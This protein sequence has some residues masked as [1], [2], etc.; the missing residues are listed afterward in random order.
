MQEVSRQAE[1]VARWS[2]GGM[3]KPGFQ[4]Y[5]VIKQTW[6]QTPISLTFWRWSLED[7]QF[8]GRGHPWTL[9]AIWNYKR[10]CL[11]ITTTTI[12]TITIGQRDDS[13]VAPQL[14][15]CTA[16]TEDQ[17]SVPSLTAACNSSCRDS[18]TFALH[19]HRQYTCLCARRQDHTHRIKNKIVLERWLS[20]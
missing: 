2:L 16:L 17:S 8:N 12:I 14:R 1:N 18:D 15:A 5:P 13:V 11:K 9:E 10:P 3:P 6:G 20:G 19:R 7:Q 4:P